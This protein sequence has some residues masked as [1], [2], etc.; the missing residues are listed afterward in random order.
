ML[1]HLSPS[2][3]RIAQHCFSNQV[4]IGRRAGG[5][6]AVSKLGPHGWHQV[7]HPAGGPPGGRAAVAEMAWRVWQ[8]VPELDTCARSLVLFSCSTSV[9]RPYWQRR[10]IPLASEGSYMST[11]QQ[12]NRGTTQPKI[13]QTEFKRKK[14]ESASIFQIK[15]KSKYELSIG[16]VWGPPV[17][18]I[19][20]LYL[21]ILLG[22]CPVGVRA[23]PVP[24]AMLTWSPW[25]P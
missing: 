12:V 2:G 6:V 13:R 22:G 20:L 8:S 18:F 23:P 11:S 5:P 24:Q 16:T 3:S 17:G 19:P 9:F 25:F 15:R 4:A 10:W 21:F 1:T 7:S 14:H